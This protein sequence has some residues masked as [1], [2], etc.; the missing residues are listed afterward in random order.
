MRLLSPGALWWLLLAAIIVFF[1]LLKLKRKRTVVPSVLLWTRAL[2][3]V[4]ANAPFKKLRRSL[5]L[6]LQLLAL[7]ALVFALARPLVITRALASGSTVIVIDSTASMSARDENGGSRLDRA[8]QL[9]HEMIEGLNASD[10][11]A[12]IESSSRVT[13]RS[14]LTSDRAS[15]VTAI[16]DVRETDAPG[17]LTDAVRLAE[18]MAK[19][20]RD[21][22]VVIIGDGGGSPIVSETDSP[23]ELSA[24][25]TGA[26]LAGAIRF[27]RVGRRSDN[28]GIIALNSRQSPGN[29]RRELFAS[30]VNFSD[31]DRTIGVE[32]KIEGKLIDAR[33]IDLGANDRRALTFDSVPG[34]EA[35]AELKLDV[36]DDLAADNVAYAFLPNTRKVRVGVISENPFLLEALTANSEVSA[37]KVSAG[38]SGAEFDCIVSDGSGS[39]E[40][41]RPV[42]A[43]NPP[44]AAGLWR[45]TG[46]RDH[47]EVNSVDRSHPVNSFLSYADL[48]VENITN[49][50]TASWLKPI[51]SDGNDPLIWAGDD[52][53]RRIVMIGFDL[54]R[55]DLPLKV[56]FPI[57]LA[58]AMSWLAGRDPAATERAIRAGQ[59]E[60]IHTSLASASITTP[61]G[62]TREVA[63][64]DGSIVFADTLRTGTYEVKAAPPFAVSLLSEAE[65][66]TAPRDSIKSRAGEA[67]GQMEAFHSEREAWRWIALFALAVLMTEWWM[68]QRKVIV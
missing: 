7:S 46:Q 66:N 15:L 43:I 34:Q 12:I 56:E 48:H 57:L 39:I 30:I 68:Y 41:N 63:A 61:E 14:P 37:S 62:D 26:P 9:A 33:T 3:E 52:G 35:L 28:V 65:S 18:Q 38:T 31:H 47:P 22:S 32:L 11:A 20:E 44:D 8:K 50:E 49:R 25:T 21:A 55:S 67:A 40:A 42:L 23:L 58:N 2:E 17:N 29:S 5:L 19:S 45:A 13:V 59:T 51:V 10:R 53:R 4:E 60:T 36:E 16:A 6:L 64:R 24:R 54:T 27:V 1:Y